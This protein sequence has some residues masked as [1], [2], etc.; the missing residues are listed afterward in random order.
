MGLIQ[1]VLIKSIPS[2]TENETFRAVQEHEKE[3]ILEKYEGNYLLHV[4]NCLL[5]FTV[6]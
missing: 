4:D 3:S 1:C 6:Y 2:L 5:L